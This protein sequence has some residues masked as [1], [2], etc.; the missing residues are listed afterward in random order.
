MKTKLNSWLGASALAAFTLMGCT[1]DDGPDGPG[2]VS[3]RFVIASTPTASDGVADYLL[4]AESLTSGTISTVGNGIEQDG[5]YRYYITINNKFFSLL[6]GQGNPGAVTTYQLNNQGELAKLSD[7]QA[8]TV[9]AFAEID[10]D[11]LMMKIPRSGAEDATWYQLDTDLLQITNDGLTNVVDVANNGERAHF[12]W[13]TQVGDKVFAPYMSIKG[14][15]DDTFGTNNPDSAWV[16]VYDYPSMELE[17]VIKDDRTSYIGRYF[18]EGLTEVE[19][20]DVYAF[21]SSVATTNGDASSS[22]P[23][24]FVRIKAGETEFDDSYYFNIEEVADGYHVTD[25]TYLGNG[26]FVVNMH[27]EKGAY[28]TGARLG[29]VDVYEESFKWVSGTPDAASVLRVTTNNYSLMD[30]N[31]AYIGFTTEQGSWVYEVDANAATATQG[32]KVEGGTITAISKL[33]VAE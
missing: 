5:T 18:T 25:K 33:D 2:Y 32:L 19:N 15:C 12:T 17:K 10:D 28:T 27:N 11:L 14:C 20:G 4:T 1:N 23:S 24:A 6:Y 21:S 9:Q 13:L 22:L 3:E 7:F 16:A 26:K 31:T 30:G 29:I 8:E